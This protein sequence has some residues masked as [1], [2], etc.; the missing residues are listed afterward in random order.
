MPR[1][2]CQLG[3]SLLTILFLLLLSPVCFGAQPFAPADITI[4]DTVL[5]DGVEPIGANLTTIAGGTNFAINNH[6]WNSGF[7]P[8]VV[9]KFIRI[10]RAGEDW[11]EWDSFGGPGYWNLAWTGLLNGATVRFYRIVDAAGDPLDYGG[12]TNMDDAAGADHVVFLGASTIPLPSVEFPDGGYIANDDRDGDTGN[13]LARVYIAAKDLGLRFGDY[14]Y[15]K[16]KTDYIGPE[17]SPPD[18]RENWTGDHPYLT[19]TNGGA[20]SGALVTHPAPVPAA[21]DD[22]GDTC[23]RATFPNT[24]VIRLGQYVYHRYD[25]SEGQ[26]YSQLTPGARYRVSVWLRQEGLGDGGRVRFVFA[27]SQTYAGVNQ[28]EPWTVTDQW[29]QF[30]FDF[31]A[32]E[33]PDDYQ[34]HTSHNLEFT[35]PGQVW[36]DNFVLYRYDAAH[37]YRPFTPHTV[38]FD[39]MMASMPAT[40]PKPAIR[41]YGT[42]FHPS[43]IEAMMGDYGNGTYRVAW[44]A[45]V[46]GGPDTTVAQ[47]L[48]WAYKTGD[49]P[50]T[51]V[52]PYL[53]CLEEYTEDE[54][55]ALV[56]FLG[57]PYDPAVDTPESKPYAY[58]RYKYRQNDGTPWT[59]AFREIVIEYGNETWHQ[60]AGGYG[61]DGWGRPGYVHH[62]GLEYGLFARYMFDENVKRMPAWTQY[63][64]GSKIKF[65]LG[66]NYSADSEAYGEKALQQGADIRYL[67]HANYVGPKWETNDPGTSV[68]DDH[69]VQ[70]TLLALEGGM[71]SLISQAAATRDSLN[72]NGSHYA[73]TAYEGGPSGYWTNDDNP[74]I[75]ELYGKSVAMGAA[76]LDAWLFS[77]QNGY[78]YQCYLGFSAGKW[79]SSHTLP[80]AG[81]FRPH[82]G[83]LALKLRNRYAQ[84]TE[85]VATV[86]NSQPTLD[87]EGAQLPLISSYALRDDNSYSVFLISRKLNGDHD[88]VAFG[89]GMTPVTLHLP[90]DQVAGITRYRLESPDGSSVDPRSNNRERLNVVIGSQTIDPALFAPT[91]VVNADT[92]G[93]EGG[94]PPGSINLLVFDTTVQSPGDDASGGSD[95]DDNSGDGVGDDASGGGDDAP[96]NGG[97]DNSSDNGDDNSGGS[98]G[99]TGDGSGGCF[100]LTTQMV[101]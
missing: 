12:G 86:H 51:R 85:M 49:S 33:Y 89:A 25:D 70:M 14:A 69:G 39:E 59:D 31:T 60:G 17:T 26:W 42:I 45:G 63:Q 93:E 74:E 80:E 68:F 52:V 75:D 77:S 30:T 79:W 21:F 34:W 64:L 23:L 3:C 82:P 91:F 96:G 66:A 19:A 35:G 8:M 67:G 18:L 43:S 61:W 57:V 13:D 47:C 92:G 27:G 2:G 40:G 4:T 58:L 101:E 15:I 44:N 48:Y 90:F 84:G 88:G 11:F 97:G 56:E 94:I 38:S 6:V 29:Q 83:W 71:R 37:E 87:N 41:F 5:A 100:I 62:G 73:L 16:L 99:A 20:W 22:G 10:D 53:T 55:K 7:E 9:R 98:S 50:E 36:I 28:T 24:G 1:P 32:P 95:G 54:W 78:G 81:G 65:A 72:A 76:A 46:E